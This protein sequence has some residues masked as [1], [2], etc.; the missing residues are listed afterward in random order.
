MSHFS[1]E[2]RNLNIPLKKCTTFEP[3]KFKSNLDIPIK[4]YVEYCSTYSEVSLVISRLRPN[5]VNGPI[6]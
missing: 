5:H 4:L 1:K 6:I 3:R 2:Y